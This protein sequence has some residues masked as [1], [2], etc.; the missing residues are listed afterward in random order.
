MLR[1]PCVPVTLSG[2]NTSHQRPCELWISSAHPLD[3]SSGGEE[4]L[5]SDA[6][7]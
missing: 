7:M 3:T 2:R 1:A 4:L 6:D 5:R